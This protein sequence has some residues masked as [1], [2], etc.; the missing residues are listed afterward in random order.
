MGGRGRRV[1]REGLWLEGKGS[2]V[3]TG[4][5]G[6]KVQLGPDPHLGALEINLHY[7]LSQDHHRVNS[8]RVQMSMP[9]K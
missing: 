7:G 1:G 4:G 5:G 9:M 8:A 3:S 2:P 6:S